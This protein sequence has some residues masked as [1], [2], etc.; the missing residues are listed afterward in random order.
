MVTN[1]KACNFYYFS[2]LPKLLSNLLS[3]VAPHHS[4]STID[5]GSALPRS[6]RHSLPTPLIAA[7]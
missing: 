5:Y 3:Y 2:F 4:F 7:N 6:R 1:F